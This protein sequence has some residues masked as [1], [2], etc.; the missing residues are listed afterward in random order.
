MTDPLSI[1]TQR[2]SRAVKLILLEFL[3]FR[4]LV[5]EPNS[6]IS[7]YK[8][9]GVQIFLELL[10]THL[11]LRESRIYSILS[12]NKNNFCL[13]W[14]AGCSIRQT[15]SSITQLAQIKWLYVTIKI[16]FNVITRQRN[17][18][19]TFSVTI[20]DLPSWGYSPCSI[21]YF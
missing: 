20:L 11:L 6:L 14:C 8:V 18:K 10:T 5:I 13:K 16:T 17:E 1:S 7:I 4:H 21:K 9:T 19:A 12:E 3:H 2:D 15:W